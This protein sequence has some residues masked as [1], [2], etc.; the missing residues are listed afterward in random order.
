M[1]TVDDLGTVLLHLKA[2]PAIRLQVRPD[3]KMAAARVLMKCVAAAVHG[4]NAGQA[5]IASQLDGNDFGYCITVSGTP[6]YLPKN[7][8]QMYEGLGSMRTPY[9]IYMA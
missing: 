5:I 6:P 3:V 4:S 2:P 1:I 8:R 9:N 7:G